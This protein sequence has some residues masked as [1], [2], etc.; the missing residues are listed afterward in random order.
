M[1]DKCKGSISMEVGI[2]M[3]QR[4]ALGDQ[5]AA[6]GPWL[7]RRRCGVRMEKTKMPP[8]VSSAIVTNRHGTTF[9]PGLPLSDV[10]VQNNSRFSVRGHNP[11]LTI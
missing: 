5:L 11:Y 3:R 6:L 4:G 2:V 10:I 8:P 9:N 7:H 1:L